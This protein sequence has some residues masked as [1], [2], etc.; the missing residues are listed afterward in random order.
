[1]NKYT[2]L[3]TALFILA[4]SF[5]VA[6]PLS[7]ERINTTDGLSS[8]RVFHLFQDSYGLL[9]IGTENGLNL[10]D[11]YNFKVFKN[12]PDN[13]E[14]IN[15]NVIWWIVEDAEKNLWIATGEGV[16]KYLRA[17]N[18]FVN[19]DF[20]GEYYGSVAIYIDSKKN[21]W[22]TVER[23]NILKYNKIDDTWDEQKF[24]VDSSKAIR[25]PAH[26]TKVMEDINGKI[27]IASIRYGLMW[28]DENESVFKQSEIIHD[29]KI[30]DF[31][32]NAKFITDLYSD[33]TGVL[34]I[35]SRGGIHKYNPAQKTFQTI[36][37]YASD[38][39][40]LNNDYNSITQD[41]F[42]NIWIMNNFNGL[43]KFEGISDTFSRI[44]LSGQNY[45]D[46]G[47][48]DLVLS[49]SLWDKSG[50]LWIGTF[51]EGLVKYDPNKKIFA[52]HVHDKNNQNSI[53]STEIYSISESKVYPDMIYVGT[54]G[55]GL[56]LFNTK[57]NDFSTIP[58]KFINDMF[59]GS[60]R[61][62]L[63]EEDGSLWV[64]TW[65]D[66]LLKKDPKRQIIK[67]F[68]PDSS[69]INSISGNR[70]RVIRKEP[71]GNLWIGTYNG[72]LTYFD[73]Q[74][75]AF[76]KLNREYA[77][78][79]RELVDLIKSKISKNSDVAKII[80]VGDSQ[81]LTAEFEVKIPG[82]YLVVTSGEGDYTDFT[83]WDYGWIEDG[84][85]KLLW[86]SNN[87]DSTYH[88]GGALKNRIKIEILQLNSGNYFLKYKSDDS[89][90]FENWNSAP[91]TEP[92]FWGIR[93][94]KIDDQ[95]EFNS[96]QK[97][98][99][100]IRKKLFVKGTNIKDIHLSDNNIV[101]VGTVVNGLHKIDKDKNIVKTYLLNNK[102]NNSLSDININDIYESNEGILWI[103]TNSGLIEFD[104]VK[105]T[106]NT[107]T[108]RDGLPTNYIYS[109][110]PGEKNG[111]W[112]STRNGLSKMIDISSENPTYVNYGIE[113]GLGVSDFTPLVALK[114]NNEKYFF[115]GDKGLIEF[116]SEK[117][118]SNPPKLIFSD[119]KISNE[120]VLKMDEDI[121]GEKSIMDLEAMLLNHTQND[122]SFEFAALHFSDPR[123][124]K[125]AHQLVGYEED[126][127]YDDKGNATYTNL[128]P[129]EYTFKFKGSNS[130]GIWNETGKS[131]SII[132]YPPW[133][134]TIWAYIGYGFLFVGIIYGF[135]RFQ[136]RRLL[137]K[138]K[139][140]MKFQ[141]VE[142]RAENAELQAKATEAER[143]V[144]ETEYN[145]KK[146]ELD[147]ARKLQ[148][149]ML[150]KEIP[151]IPNLDIAVYMKTATEV[152]GDYYDVSLK[153]DGSVNIAIGDATGHG[154]KAGTLVSMMKS[155]FTANSVIQ[156]I[157]DFF[158]TSNTALKKANIVRMMI[159]F[160]M[161]NIKG[162]KAKIMNAGMPPIYHYRSELNKVEEIDL[163]GTPLGAL[164]GSNYEHYE[165]GLNKNDIL[166][167]MSDGFPELNDNNDMM[168]G[169][170]RVKAAFEN[171]TNGS[172]EEVI[173]YLKSEVRSWMKEKD[174]E[175]DV[176][177][178]VVKM[179]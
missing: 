61:S 87:I 154:M 142:H 172:P 161:I 145:L 41:R 112:L 35:T 100:N 38:N 141:E 137:A 135:D 63:E 6:Q 92:E 29:D 76:I 130:E 157:N 89:H 72:G 25:S 10:Y 148:L 175:D 75:N 103:A 15:S 48:S 97:Y 70:V 144:L 174:L 43:L 78:Y 39:A 49:R 71:S 163:H 115:G 105:E 164:L 42:G 84:N 147:E 113:D 57:T 146:K 108:E 178:V 136:K 107:F 51:S 32:Y 1:M 118:I 116:T 160:A 69:D 46:D 52:H 85:N 68:I 64:G 5:L 12:D 74:T 81:N 173:T 91:P 159:G 152:G 50:I 27:W 80:K 55:G 20:Y 8:N 77:T 166:L 54:R 30:E 126:W 156:E 101:W 9:W 149:S 66:G 111:F 124:N 47:K 104:P 110:L 60:V 153:N 21:I 67:R 134:M 133:W 99:T 155:L 44:E 31:T 45:S 82:N 14:S 86:K 88:V 167:L 170:E 129:G 158:T 22:A 7:V 58:I 79:P 59:G 4:T 171:I 132:I 109:I 36:Q 122:L 94:F 90:S 93:I 114:T 128:D 83:L 177:F 18:K 23:K 123:K 13:S 138:A 102:N 37:R 16:S 119:L 127:I 139:E 165:I 143:R 168:Y 96:I 56:N 120:S 121:L 117:S 150:P 28:Y 98:T 34:W 17:E 40:N 53:S 169:Y 179:K 140:R 95:R 24:V 65:G 125:Y 2:F 19:Y 131:I 106:F 151:S 62:I 33:S 3:F 176:T 162:S 11:G 26:V 73:V